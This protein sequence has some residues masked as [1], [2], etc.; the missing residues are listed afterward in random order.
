MKEFIKEEEEEQKEVEQNR[1]SRLK[2]KLNEKD[3]VWIT[4]N[5]K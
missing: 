5:C 2:T 4:V 3:W 1:G